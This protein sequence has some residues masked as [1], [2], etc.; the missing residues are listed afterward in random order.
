MTAT[1]MA[2]EDLGTTTVEMSTRKA[3][4]LSADFAC[5]STDEV[6]ELGSRT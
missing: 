3:L 1:D 4:V 2:T 6:S 5:S